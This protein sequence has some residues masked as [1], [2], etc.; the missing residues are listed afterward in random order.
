MKEKTCCFTGHRAIPEA[1]QVKVAVS[2]RIA[3]RELIRDKVVYMSEHYTRDCMFRRNR[4]LV[5]NSSV[6]ICYLT[7]KRGGTAYT[8]KYAE[9]EG[10]MVKNLAL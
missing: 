6:C 8:V 1:Q 7:G 4:H 5:D 3:V 10:I 2:L 9:Q